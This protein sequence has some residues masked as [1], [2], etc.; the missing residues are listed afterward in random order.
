MK[1][2]FRPKASVIQHWIEAFLDPRRVLGIAYLP[3]YFGNWRQ[4]RRLA[5][6][7]VARLSDSFPCLT[8]VLPHTPFDPHYFYQACWAARKVVSQ[9]PKLHVDIG[10][11]VVVLGILSAQ[12]PTLFIDYRPLRVHVSN[13]QSIGGDIGRLPFAD[14]SLYSVSCLHVIEHIG[15]GRYGDTL[16]PHGSEKA[17]QELVR[18]LAPGG[19]LLISTPIGR[20]RVQFNAHRVFAP[21]T[22]LHLFASLDLVDFAAVDDNRSFHT[23]IVPEQ[24]TGCDYACGMFEFLKR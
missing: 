6:S 20:E 12:V 5:S 3:R 1:S 24:L 9:K 19:Q 17:A 2:Y 10:S 8:D 15:L 11:S 22:V 18:V 13:L 23:S 4:Y 16:D 21:Q 7:D 14:A